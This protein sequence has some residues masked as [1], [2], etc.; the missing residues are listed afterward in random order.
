MPDRHRRANG[1]PP[2]TF[3]RHQLISAPSGPI[4]GPDR[5]GRAA[6]LAGLGGR[7]DL[8]PVRGR[9]GDHLVAD[10]PR[11][12]LARGARAARRR[13]G[14][15]ELSEQRVA[16]RSSSADARDPRLAVARTAAGLDGSRSRR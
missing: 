6:R 9:V 15:G 14:L 11:A 1:H 4:R 16:V 10:L 5:P 3:T 7:D 13:A 12:A 2:E 8:P